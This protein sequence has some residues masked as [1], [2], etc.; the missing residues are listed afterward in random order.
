V[1]KTISLFGIE[2]T[3]ASREEILGWTLAEADEGSQVA[4]ATL[5]A[6]MVMRAVDDPDF[7]RLLHSREIV[8]PD[9]R[10]IAESARR[11][12]AERIEVYP[13][14]EFAFDLVKA[15]TEGTRSVFLL[16]SKAGVAEKAVSHLLEAIP[17]CR[18]AG[19]HH[20]YFRGKDD[21][22]V[23]LINESKATILLAGMGSPYQEFWL[24]ENR[25]RLESRILAGVGGSFE[26]W[27]G[28]HRRAPKW[29][30]RIGLE[31]L[32][33]ALRDP[34]RLKRLGFIPRYLALE[35]AEIRRSKRRKEGMQ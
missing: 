34:G 35:R 13:G 15:T 26:V 27:A 31:W 8:I 1:L 20:G 17:G 25:E 10:S 5:N 6:E 33:R 29:M 30:S 12:L 23:A 24:E 32:Y 22:I 4:I 18:I 19:C 11:I 7:L 2:I 9:G 28:L 21:R 14:I 3:C 16:G